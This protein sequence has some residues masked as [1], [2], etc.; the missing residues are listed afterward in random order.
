MRAAVEVGGISVDALVDSGAGVSVIQRRWL[1][2]QPI[3]SWVLRPSFVRLKG[4]TGE[5]I[6]ADG[7]VTLSLQIGQCI[8]F[9]SF[10]VVSDLN[11]QVILGN[12]TL[13]ALGVVIDYHLKC[14]YCGPPCSKEGMIPQGLLVTSVAVTIPACTQVSIPVETTD[15]VWV[16]ADSVVGPVDVADGLTS[17]GLTGKKCEVQLSR[18][19]HT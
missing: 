2:A 14:L 11:M 9:V 6:P 13:E 16:E 3:D 18:P 8:K 7:E 10:V 15:I 4:I 5:Y 17:H 12:D 19:Q 1:E